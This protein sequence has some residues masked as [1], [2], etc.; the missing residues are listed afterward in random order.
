MLI[1]DLN[2]TINKKNLGVFM[3]TFNLDSL[4]N[5]PTSISKSNLY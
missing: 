5:K 2:L 4:I 1:G 3:D